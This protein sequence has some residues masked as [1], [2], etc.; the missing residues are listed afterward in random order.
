M[1][2]QVPFVQLPVQFDAERLAAEMGALGDEAWR[3]HPQKFPGN[4]ALPLISVNGDP[5]SDSI[6]GPMRPTDYLDR[7]PYLRHTLAHLGA[8]WGRT[9]LMKLTGNA[10]V[11]RHADTN[12]YWRERVRVHV[13]ILTRPAVRFLCGDAEVN[14]AP[15]E[16]W[17]FD[18]WREHRVIN[19]QEAERVHLVADTVGSDAFWERVGRG[20]ALGQDNPDWHAEPL[21]PDNRTPSDLF[22]ESVNVPRVM[23][24]W[25][26]REHIG[27]LLRELRPHPGQQ[28]FLQRATRFFMAWQA[29]W[30]EHGDSEAGWGAYRSELDEFTAAIRPHTETMQLVNGTL[31]FKTLQTMVLG[32]ALADRRSIP[33]ATE[34]RRAA[35]GLH[36]VTK[37]AD[38]E[39]DRPIFIVSSP[40]SGSTVL[41][42]TLARA[43]R[44]HTIGGES[45]ALIEGVPGLRMAMQGFGSNR[46]DA[47]AASPEVVAEL[48]RRFLAQLHDRD[49]NPPSRPPIRM[50]EKTPKNALRVPFLAQAFPDARFVY[51][52]RDPR[53]TLASMIE[54]WQSG[55]FCTYP[56]LP[57]WQGL[58]WSLLLVPGWRELIGKSLHE[59]V[60]AQWRITTRILLDDLAVLPAERLCAIRYDNF[61]AD[62]QAETSALCAALDME[63]DQSLQGELPAS[64]YT[65]TAPAAQKWRRHQH[66][67]ETVLPGLQAEIERAER[68]TGAARIPGT[69]TVA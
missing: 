16:C 24:P 32:V 62:P 36:T 4:F 59:I 50:L 26:L 64:R 54:A 23:S 51:L 68:M 19:A 40:R 6:A 30:A 33:Q 46:L 45:H 38:A 25:E 44:L 60:A 31:L 63:W 8:V 35:P 20:R 22:L 42:E 69:A 53:E 17:I 2:L 37:S 47:M 21:S 12:Y 3:P 52:Y 43:P 65:V 27:F 7:C 41:F 56:R 61:I 66:D 10:E 48:R 5:D 15:G 1:K 18:T 29:L 55:R 9:R 57:G 13:P 14:M 58:P 28:P 39:F 11:S 34:E 49:G 67:I